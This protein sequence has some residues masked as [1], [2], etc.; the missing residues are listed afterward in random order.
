MIAKI[1]TFIVVFSILII[2][3]WKLW[4]RA[5]FYEILARKKEMETNF[6]N[7]KLVETLSDLKEQDKVNSEKIQD[8]LH[9]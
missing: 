9:K 2:I 4:K 8:F 1:L 7:A 3:F 5:D 6:E